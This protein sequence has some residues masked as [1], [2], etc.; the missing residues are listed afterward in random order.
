MDYIAANIK[1]EICISMAGNSDSTN[2][3]DRLTS[4]WPLPDNGVRQI[5]PKP[6]LKQLATHPLASDLHPL[7]MGFYPQA[8]QHSMQRPE[9]I[10]YLLIY[11]A[12]GAGELMLEQT[13]HK[14]QAG[15]LILLPPGYAHDYRA[16]SQKPWSIYW[17]H[18]DG[19][20]VENYIKQMFGDSIILN[21]G[22]QASVKSHFELLFEMRSRGLTLANFL[23]IASSLKSLFLHLAYLAQLPSQEGSLNHS[24][25]PALIYMRAN[26]H[27]E[28]NLD[29]LAELCHL[30]KFHFVRK[31]KAYT[32]YAPIQY[33]I[34]LKMEHACL[35]LDN[36]TD[37]IKRVASRL[38]YQDPL[39][40][41][42]LFKQMLGVSPSQYRSLHSA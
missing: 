2:H 8:Q 17:V 10:T 6:L 27:Q 22:L 3:D 26:I 41:S 36:S 11:C 31:F 15:N 38:G 32:G 30:S 1:I 28:I 24:L 20:L 34:Q 16:D 33:F 23:C 9:H 39:Y 35:L 7:A 29:H 40:F 37:P 12:A 25:R 42:R 14:V 21:I 18:F 5:T 19:K 4:H 13:D